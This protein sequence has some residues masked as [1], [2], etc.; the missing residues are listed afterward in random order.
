MQRS[1]IECDF[2]ARFLRG[3]PCPGRRYRVIAASL[4]TIPLRDRDAVCPR[5]PGA[6]KRP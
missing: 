2:G 5:P 6:A 1:P 4:G 3:L